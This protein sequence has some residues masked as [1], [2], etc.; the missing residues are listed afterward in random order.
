[1]NNS[2]WNYVYKVKS[3]HLN[4]FGIDAYNSTAD[5]DRFHSDISPYYGY[6]VYAHGSSAHADIVS[7]Y[8]TK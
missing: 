1:M 8:F 6:G 4:Y 7:S 3:S 5:I 2:W